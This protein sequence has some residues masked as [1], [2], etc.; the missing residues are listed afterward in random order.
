MATTF[1]MLLGLA[2]CTGSEEPEQA[3]L[4]G[5]AWISDEAA[6]DAL[7]SEP[8]GRE[9]ESVDGG[10]AASNVLGCRVLGDGGYGA[11]TQVRA[12]ES[13]DK[14]LSDVEASRSQCERPLPLDVA[15]ADGLVCTSS[16]AATAEGPTAWGVWDGL[17][18]T[19]QLT[20]ADTT[21]TGEDA[22]ARLRPLVAAAVAEVSTDDLEP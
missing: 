19:A 7:G 6:S 3:E 8:T 12:V 13:E 15:G 4:D 17:Q 9:D 1:A 18:V 14:V 5:C 10:G 11:I 16:D 20:V 22:A 21:P 2:A